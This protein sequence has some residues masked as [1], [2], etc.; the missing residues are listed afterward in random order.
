MILAQL[1]IFAGQ[2]RSADIWRCLPDRQLLPQVT[3]RQPFAQA[4]KLRR[5]PRSVGAAA[6]AA[7]AD[8]AF[9]RC[10]KRSRPGAA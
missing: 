3:Q 2:R 4:T 5:K 7:A 6:R 1:A 8:L 9:R 10:S